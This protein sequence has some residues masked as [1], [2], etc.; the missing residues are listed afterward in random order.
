MKKNTLNTIYENT[1]KDFMDSDRRI[2]LNNKQSDIAKKVLDVLITSYSTNSKDFE[3]VL[4]IERQLL[5]YKLA[6]E[7]ALT[8]KNAAIAFMNYLLGN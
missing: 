1:Y 8:D 2:H 7:K 5:T 4:R 3:E 6:Y